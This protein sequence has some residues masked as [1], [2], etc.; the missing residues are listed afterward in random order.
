[1]C[2]DCSYQF[3]KDKSEYTISLWMVLRRCGSRQCIE[4]S[5]RRTAFA[6]ILFNNIDG[7]VQPQPFPRGVSCNTT[8]WVGFRHQFLA[9]RIHQEAN[10]V[11]AHIMAP[12]IGQCFRQM[13][14]I[15]INL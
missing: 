10:Q 2:I 1:M 3:V 7:V 15:K 13:A 5:S 12:K 4:L 11:W 8:I 14:L 9:T 6:F